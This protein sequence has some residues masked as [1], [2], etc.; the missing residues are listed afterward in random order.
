MSKKRV[1]EL[2]K[3]LKEQGIELSNSELTTHVEKI[4]TLETRASAGPAG[5]TATTTTEPPPSDQ[6]PA[7]P[8]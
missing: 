7:M 1:H 6:P 3:Q 4:R 8:M 5:V 2:G